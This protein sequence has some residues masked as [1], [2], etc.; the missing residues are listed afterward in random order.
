MPL[1]PPIPTDPRGGSVTQRFEVL[2]G[3]EEVGGQKGDATET[4]P[5]PAGGGQ[6]A[7]YRT[8]VSY[9]PHTPTQESPQQ[10]DNGLRT[11]TGVRVIAGNI[12]RCILLR[13]KEVEDEGG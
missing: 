1:E 9:Q 11:R 13:E 6:R 10:T 7:V 5:K 12:I 4:E 3:M 8:T 2:S